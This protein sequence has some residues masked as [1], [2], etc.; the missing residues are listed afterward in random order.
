[1]DIST[2]ENQLTP[3]K[4]GTDTTSPS[5]P[6]SSLHAVELDRS[7]GP[8]TAEDR[9]NVLPAL[10]SSTAH[11]GPR[12][13]PL[14]TN[15][16]IGV[17][18]GH[19]RDVHSPT[20]RGATEHTA[21]VATTDI[22]CS[23]DTSLKTCTESPLNTPQ[24]T[25]APELQVASPAT[26]LHVASPTTIPQV[27]VS[28]ATVAQAGTSTG[29]T[30][31][32]SQPSTLPMATGTVPVTNLL[33]QDA[34][35]LA[36]P[37]S[38]GRL[39]HAP[40]ASTAPAERDTSPASIALQPGWSVSSVDLNTYAGRNPDRPVIPPRTSKKAKVDKMTKSLKKEA[41]DREHRALMEAVQ[42]CMMRREKEIEE[43]AEAHDKTQQYIRRLLNDE[44]HY[45]QK[46]E[47]NLFNA[48]IHWKSCELNAGKP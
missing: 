10:L 25:T 28:P 1:M 8:L 9:H 13:E 16:G 43:L 42:E 35:E 21:S 19:E 20:I 32:G 24:I 31:T 15:G 4:A 48:K 6:S 44:T 41:R 22:T 36:T 30:A 45:G 3:L 33:E 17:T 11:P 46:R 34:P 47:V 14:R 5:S 29:T 7:T 26:N 12:N 27:N 18:I 39:G 38:A 37:S 40:V 2:A 23:T